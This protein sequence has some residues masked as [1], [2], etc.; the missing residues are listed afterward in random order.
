MCKL[1]K[2]VCNLLVPLYSYDEISHIVLYAEADSSIKFKRKV[3]ESSDFDKC[4]TY[5]CFTNLLPGEN[6]KEIIQKYMENDKRIRLIKNK[7][8]R[9]I[10]FC[11][12]IGALNSKGKYIIE[13][14]PEF[15]IKD[16]ISLIIRFDVNSI[17]KGNLFI[18]RKI[19]PQLN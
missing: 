17:K 18:Y 14:D 5:D 19:N 13:V 12:S 15:E 10:L 4:D 3:I 9:R 8:N 11:K 1:N 6:E 2:K 16:K 7:V